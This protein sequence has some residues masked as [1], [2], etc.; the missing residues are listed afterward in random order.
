MAMERVGWSTVLEI[1]G[2]AIAV[3]RDLP[4]QS[5]AEGPLVRDVGGLKEMECRACAE[6]DGLL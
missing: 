5:G 1:V 3:V 6:L 2:E 4:G